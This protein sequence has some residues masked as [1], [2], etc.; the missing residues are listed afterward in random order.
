[1]VDVRATAIL[2]CGMDEVPLSKSNGVVFSGKYRPMSA[3]TPVT[4]VLDP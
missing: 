4:T 1:M 3:V 2:A